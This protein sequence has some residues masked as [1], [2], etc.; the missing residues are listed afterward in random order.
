MLAS[1]SGL[2]ILPAARER[3]S[4]DV[5][6]LAGRGTERREGE[7]RA[8]RGRGRF[9]DSAVAFRVRLVGAEIAP[10]TF[11]PSRLI[12]P[13]Y[14]SLAG[15]SRGL[16]KMSRLRMQGENGGREGRRAKLPAKSRVAD[17]LSDADDGQTRGDLS[18][19]L[20]FLLLL[21]L[22]PLLF[23]SLLF[24]FFP[25]LFCDPSIRISIGLGPVR[26]VNRETGRVS[27]G[28]AAISCSF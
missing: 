18:F 4:D 19:S 9:V 27:F 15:K 1:I 5:L 28:H 24:L 25:L 20:P 26:D 16:I 8:P 13:H 22:F 17:P 2:K 3:R 10:K 7:A 14:G 12:F 11:P 21:S 23:F 6:N